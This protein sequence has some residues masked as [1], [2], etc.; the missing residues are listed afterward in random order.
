MEIALV[1]MAG[2]AKTVPNGYAQR[3]CMENRVIKLAIVL[4]RTLNREF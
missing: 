1:K 3:T 2:K 4:Q